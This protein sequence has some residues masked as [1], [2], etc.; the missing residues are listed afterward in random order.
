MPD[1]QKPEKDEVKNGWGKISTG[2]VHNLSPQNSLGLLFQE[3]LEQNLEIVG[4]RG[5]G[6]LKT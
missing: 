2:E 3:V 5:G 4:L 6:S 1:N